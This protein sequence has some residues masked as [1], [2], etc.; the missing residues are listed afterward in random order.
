M[1]CEIGRYQAGLVKRHS[2]RVAFFL[3]GHVLIISA[4]HVVLL[5][6]VYQLRIA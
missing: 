5:T 2:L 4:P 1:L 6:F 3:H